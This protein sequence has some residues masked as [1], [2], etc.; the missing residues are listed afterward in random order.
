MCNLQWDKC[1]KNIIHTSGAKTRVNICKTA[2]VQKLLQYYPKFV[3]YG[4]VWRWPHVGRQYRT[5]VAYGSYMSGLHIGRHCR[6]CVEYRC[7]WSG[8][9]YCTIVIKLRSRT[10]T[11]DKRVARSRLLNIFAG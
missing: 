2:T 10:T 6:K 5:L 11:L 4:N 3:E 8:R 7:I 9:Q 1:M